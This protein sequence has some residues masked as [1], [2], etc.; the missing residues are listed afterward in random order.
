MYACMHVCMYVCDG[1]G[2][3]GWVSGRG[4]DWGGLPA[5]GRDHI[6][7]YIYI[8]IFESIDPI[9]KLNAFTYFIA[10]NWGEKIMEVDA[11]CI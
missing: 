7:I 11:C 3:W 10:F 2:S 6:Y 5:A 8:F 4:F 1:N 9:W